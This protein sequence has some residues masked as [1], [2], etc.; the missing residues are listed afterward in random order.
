MDLSPGRVRVPEMFRAGRILRGESWDIKIYYSGG[1]KRN[2][3]VAVLDLAQGL[4]V[5]GQC[6]MRERPAYAER[7]EQVGKSAK[8]WHVT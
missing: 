4:V 8:G 3:R 5:S 1:G 7:K 6:I 2:P